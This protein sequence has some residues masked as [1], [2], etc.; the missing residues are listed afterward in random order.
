[1]EAE[2]QRQ[3]ILR[4]ASRVLAEHGFDGVRL[5]DIAKAAGVSIGMLQHHFETREQLLK[6]A[7][8]WGSDDILRRWGG[9]AQGEPDPWKRFVGLIEDRSGGPDLRRECITWTELC[10]SASRHSDLRP[11]VRGVYDGWRDLVAGVVEEGTRRGLFH[12]VMPAAD[13]VDLLLVTVDGCEMAIAAGVAA[14][15]GERFRTIVLSAA[16]LA[17]GLPRQQSADQ[18]GAPA[19]GGGLTRPSR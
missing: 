14:V 9:L 4:A 8:V 6:Q 19:T 16:R 11:T 5:R 3:R 13:V 12:P 17:L 7:A 2:E 18:P 1:M 10:A 15:D